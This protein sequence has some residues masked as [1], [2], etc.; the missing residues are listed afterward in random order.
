MR[1]RVEAEVNLH[2]DGMSIAIREE[3]VELEN[4]GRDR[5]GTLLKAWMKCPDRWIS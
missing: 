1:D 5:F 4:S 3:P 2:R